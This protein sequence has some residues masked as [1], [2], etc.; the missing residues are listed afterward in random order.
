MT[1]RA[2]AHLTAAEFG[3]AV[4]ALAAHVGLEQLKDRLARMN[5]FTSRRGLGTASALADRLHL[6]TGGLRRP[7]PATYAFSTLWNEMV[8]ARLG[9]DGEKRLETLADEVNACLADDESIVAGKEEALDLALAAYHDALA[10]ATG[11]EVAR[12]DMLLKAVPSVAERL[13]LRLTSGSGDAAP[14]S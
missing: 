3:E 1:G 8:A 5:A 13:R 11:P 6:L 2:M 12:L 9:E 4:S 7:A 10:G 14:G